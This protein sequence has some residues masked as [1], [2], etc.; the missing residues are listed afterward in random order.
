MP[1][2]RTRVLVVDDNHELCEVL[3]E[4]IDAQPDMEVI[5]IAYDGLEALEKI[6]ADGPDVVILD[7]IMPHLDGIGVLERLARHDMPRRPRFVMLTAIG[8]EHM[9]QRIIELGADYYILKPFDVETLAQR[10]RQVAQGGEVARK[11]KADPAEVPRDLNTE[12]TRIIHEMGMPANI[13]GYMY[14]REAIVMV[15]NE[16]ALLNGVTKE[17]YPRV[18][19]KFDTTPPRVERAIRH[20]IEIAWTRGNIEFLNDVFGHTVSS[21]KGKPTNSAFIARV[22]DKLR[23]EMRAS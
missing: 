9:T 3:R 21:E 6:S 8:Q 16:V 14:L 20:A 15:V 5:G 13:R 17:L 19:Q 23:I 12:V 2:G 4:F 1:S 10:I 22:A 11:R 18:A 7:I